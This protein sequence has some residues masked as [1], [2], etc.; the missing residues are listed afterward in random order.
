MNVTRATPI[1]SAA[2]VEAV[3]PGFR[4]EFPLASRPAAPPTRCAGQPRIDARGL[5][6]WDETM[7]T[8]VKS[9]RTPPAIASKRGAVPISSLNIARPS[10]AIASAMITIAR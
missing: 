10:A 4:I 2:A 9:K 7:A 5:T 8:P 1:M 6:R 3:R